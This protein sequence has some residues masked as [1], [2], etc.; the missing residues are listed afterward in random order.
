MQFLSRTVFTAPL[1][2]PST[3]GSFS[4]DLSAILTK[5]VFI[6]ETSLFIH[7]LVTVVDLYMIRVLVGKRYIILL[8]ENYITT[9]YYIT[10]ITLENY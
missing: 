8:L 10:T 2:L 4:K 3:V 7:I 1:L 6:V 9:R 5:M